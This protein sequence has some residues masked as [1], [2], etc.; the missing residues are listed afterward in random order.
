MLKDSTQKNADDVVITLAL[1]TPLGKAIKGGLKDTTLDGL[2]FKLLE[3]VR[4][5]SNFDPRLV[6]DICLGNVRYIELT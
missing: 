3:Q 1:R 6:G 5:K 2:L 4:L